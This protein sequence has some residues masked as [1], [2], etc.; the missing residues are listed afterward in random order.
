MLIQFMRPLM[1]RIRFYPHYR[2]GHELT[3]YNTRTNIKGNLSKMIDILD[4]AEGIAWSVQFDDSNPRYYNLRS[5]DGNGN[6]M[7]QLWIQRDPFRIT[8]TRTIKTP[9]K[10]KIHLRD[11]ED[12]HLPI[13]APAESGQAVIWKTKKRPLQYQV[14]DTEQEPSAIVLSVEKPDPARYMGFGEQGG[15]DLFK[16][17][18]YMNY[19]NFDNMRYNNCCG[20][21]NHLASRKG[22]RNFII[23][24]GSY[25]G[26]QRYAGLWTGDNASTWD[27]LQISV[28]QVIALGLAGVTIAGADVGGFEPPEGDLTAFADPELLIRWYCAYSLLPWFRNHYTAKHTYKENVNWKKK[29]F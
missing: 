27:F 7:V 6:P 8:A 25:A 11:D 10:L 26:A 14:R 29:D 4:K 23:G 13:S 17:N 16:D 21:L 2:E 1:G 3:D 9:R 24:R 12:S 28:A 15:K 19:F 5:I 20:P 22:K 18:T